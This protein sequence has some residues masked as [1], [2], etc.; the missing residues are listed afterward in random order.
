[1][2]EDKEES[3][4]DMTKKEKRITFILLTLLILFL[5][6]F[7]LGLY[8]F[9]L[10]GVFELF[11]VEYDSLWSLVVFTVCLFAVGIFFEVF[12]KAIYMLSARKLAGKI[13]LFFLR[14]SIEVTCNWMTVFT[15][16]ELMDSVTLSTQAEIFIAV[17]VALSEIAMDRDGD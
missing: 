13:N 3:S 1:M 17:L 6:G 14:L 4:A 7:M 2:L 8:F 15:V 10:V 16:D 12:F 5:A 9:G 11:G